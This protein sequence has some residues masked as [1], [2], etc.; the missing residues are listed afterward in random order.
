[1]TDAGRRLVERYLALTTDPDHDAYLA[2]FDDDAV[3]EDEGRRHEGIGA[4][5]AWWAAVPEVGYA[6]RS[7]EA[8]GDGH[9]AVVEVSGDFPGSP[10][11][12]EHGFGLGSDGRIRV[13]AIRPITP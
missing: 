6:V 11:L 10:V 4:V 5:R 1:M 2:Q 9:R 7:I 12:L 13:L 3:V 8:S